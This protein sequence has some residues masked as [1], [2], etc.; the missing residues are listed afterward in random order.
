M[1]QNPKYEVWG[2]FLKSRNKE[3]VW[4]NDDYL[5]QKNL[6]NFNC[7]FQ[8]RRVFCIILTV[9][10]NQ[11]AMLMILDNFGNTSKVLEQE[12]I[13]ELNIG[14]YVN[15]ELFSANLLPLSQ[16]SQCY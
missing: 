3:N 13:D 4:S 2:L 7:I 12:N 5:F 11:R 6:W 15:F 8:S 14:I 10:K 1:I 9:D 16:G